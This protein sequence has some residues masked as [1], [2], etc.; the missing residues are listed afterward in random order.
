[1]SSRFLR[2]RFDPANAWVSRARFV[3]IGL[4]RG[5]AHTIMDVVEAARAYIT[6]MIEQRGCDGMKV[7]YALDDAFRRCEP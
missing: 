2:R 5:V 6:K 3:A 7:R 1:M 4:R